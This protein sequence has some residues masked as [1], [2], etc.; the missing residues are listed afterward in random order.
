VTY[1]AD[2]VERP[3]PGG[4]QY[5][6]ARSRSADVTQA[7][8]VGPVAALLCD[9]DGTLIEDVPYN[10]DPDAVR[11][12]TG[13]V[14][15][16]ER[17]RAAGLRI[18]V[19][20]NQSGLARGR[21]RPSDLQAV[22]TRMTELLGPF[23]VIVSCPHGVADRCACRKPEPGLIFAAAA[24]LGVPPAACVL[25]GDRHDDI[26]AAARAGT[27]AILVSFTA[28]PSEDCPWIASSFADAVDLVL[29]AS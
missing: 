21:I 23:D 25:I 26:V 5:L 12:L 22:H 18:G 11:P 2:R 27:G 7:F 8:A 20:T 14:S 6:S 16:L 28:S 1:A 9:R 13:V 10:A 19:V 3:A 15:A 17:A 4:S 29:E 24:A